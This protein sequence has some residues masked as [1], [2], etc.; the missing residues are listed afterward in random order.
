LE[1]LLE[2][3]HTLQFSLKLGQ[4]DTLREDTYICVSLFFFKSKRQY[5]VRRTEQADSEDDGDLRITSEAGCVF[6]KERVEAKERTDIP[7]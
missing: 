2:F 7:K 1:F 5:S 6:G 3:V 4:N